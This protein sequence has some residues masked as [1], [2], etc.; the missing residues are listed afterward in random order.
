MKIFWG[1]SPLCCLHCVYDSELVPW[2]DGFWQLSNVSFI[3]DVIH[4]NIQVQIVFHVMRYFWHLS[5][6]RSESG[7][8]KVIWSKNRKRSGDQ[9]A[10]FYQVSVEIKSW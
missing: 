2:W 4:V 6:F 7:A 8:A 9:T 5:F 3:Q 1:A 10:G